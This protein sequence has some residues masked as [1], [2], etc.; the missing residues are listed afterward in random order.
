MQVVFHLLYPVH[1]APIYIVKSEEI[2]SRKKIILRKEKEK[3]K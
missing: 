3:E 2:T 1:L